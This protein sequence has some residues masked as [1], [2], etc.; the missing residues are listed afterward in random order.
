MSGACG[1]VIFFSRVGKLSVSSLAS[2]LQARQ[3]QS[4]HLDP[5]WLHGAIGRGD[6]DQL[7]QSNGYSEGTKDIYSQQQR[8]SA[9][10]TAPHL[11]LPRTHQVSFSSAK[12]RAIWMTMCYPS[13]LAASR[14]ILSSR[15]D[16]ETP[17]VAI[18]QVRSA[19]CSATF[20]RCLELLP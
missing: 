10:S 9:F 2:H 1:R 19:T 5:P 8:P 16:L 4:F 11:G 20:R 17:R 13:C 14:S 6:V 7:M 12:A 18:P 3:P 15:C